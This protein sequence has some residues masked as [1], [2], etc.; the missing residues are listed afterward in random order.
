M[1]S[2][3]AL[4]VALTLATPMARADAPVAGPLKVAP[5]GRHFVDRAGKPFFWLGD[6]AWPLLVE[7]P[8]EAAE[9]YL[10]HRGRLGFNVIQTVVAWTHGGSGAE[11]DRGPQPNVF[12][13][14]PWKN[15][16]PAT[17]NEA[18]FTNVDHLVRFAHQQGLVLAILPTWGYYVT[19]SKILTAQNARAYGRWLGARYR[20]APNVVWVLG[21]D[22]PALGFEEVWRQ[23]GAGLR[24]GDGGGHLVTYHP[25]GSPCTSSE[26]FPDDPLLSFHMIETWTDWPKVHPYVL[27]DVLRTPAKPVVLAEGAYENG[28]EYPLGPITPLIIRRQ[29]WW[30]TMAGG[31]HTYGQDQ[32]W[33]MN[34][35]WEKTFDTPGASQV[36]LM[37]TIMTGLPWWEG[38][39]DQSIFTFGAGAEPTLNT[40][41]RSRRGQWALVYL[42]SQTTVMLRLN[43]IVARR[44]RATWIDP[45]S[46]ARKEAGEFDTGNHSGREFPNRKNELFTT[47]GHWEDALLL[48]EGLP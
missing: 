10:R 31:F 28:P 21:G 3:C 32:M 19:G 30:T 26:Y 13:E 24:E 35:G 47:P 6:T 11:K 46:G 23:L 33:R 5:N 17:P 20:T 4:L 15:E 39:P 18:F 9:E 43:R 1:F 42:S 44:V 48:L 38:T 14:R 16:N 45:R 7:Y 25:C 37:K 12:G 29:A 27:F 8:R 41:F 2:R 34:P 36:A 40:A 22:R